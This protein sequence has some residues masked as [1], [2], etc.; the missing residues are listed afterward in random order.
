MLTNVTCDAL[1]EHRKQQLEQRYELIPIT[2]DPSAS[3]QLYRIPGL[4][5]II[6]FISPVS[7]GFCA[8]CNRLRLT[9]DGYLRPCLH[10]PIEIDVKGPL[11]QGATDDDIANL[12]YEAV[13]KKPRSHHNFV[14]QSDNPHEEGR[15]M[16]KIGG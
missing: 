8:T 14:M 11:R 3:A 10:G 5:G 4:R 16:V 13:E 2:G 12:F 15:A 1:K 7:E 6:G 9:A